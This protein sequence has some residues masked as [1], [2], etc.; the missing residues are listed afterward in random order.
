[1]KKTKIICIIALI[2]VTLFVPSNVNAQELTIT[3]YVVIEG[4]GSCPACHIGD[5][6]TVSLGTQWTNPVPYNSCT[7]EAHPD[8]CQVSIS[9]K[10]QYFKTTCD[11]CSY[12]R[13]SKSLLATSIDHEYSY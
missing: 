5:I 8:N 3:P 11:Y 7:I 9:Y 13:E 1:M 4:P 2:F 10:Y 6:N 12:L